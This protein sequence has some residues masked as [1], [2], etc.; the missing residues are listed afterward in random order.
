M[1]GSALDPSWNS[2]SVSLPSA[3]CEQREVVKGEGQA[4]LPQAPGPGQVPRKLLKAGQERVG[5]A[6]GV[7][8]QT[9]HFLAG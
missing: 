1:E 4:A 6:H 9:R 3:F 2:C 5:A 7:S 8:R